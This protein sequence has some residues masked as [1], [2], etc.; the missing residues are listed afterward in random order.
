MTMIETLWTLPVPS[1]ALL[2]G[3][4]FHVLPQRICTLTC[5]Y[6]DDTN[7]LASLTLYFSGVEAFR[8]TYFG[9]CT[10]EMIQMAYDKVVDIGSST[11]LEDITNQL[12]KS[13]RDSHD[14]RH[15]RMYPDDGPCYEF[16]CRFFRA[17]AEQRQ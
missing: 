16:V 9:A 8:V 12:S 4:A 7:V 13:S 17:T 15:M 6:E 5:E 1:T 11:W 3:I 14:L 10:P 2:S